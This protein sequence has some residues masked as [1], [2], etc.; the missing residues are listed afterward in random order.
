[1]AKEARNY[2]MSIG[3]KNSDAIL[4]QVEDVIQFAV[5]EECAAN[6]ECSV[7][8]DFLKRKPV[9]HIEYTKTKS[10]GTYRDSY[11]TPNKGSSGG[12]F[13]SSGNKGS[14]WGSSSS[15][16]S[17]KPSSSNS[18]GLLGGL[19]GGLGSFFGRKPNTRNNAIEVAEVAEVAEADYAG[20]AAV[21]KYCTPRSAPDLGPKFSTVIK[22]EALDGWVRFCDGRVA[23]TRILSF[24]GNGR[25]T[26]DSEG[27]DDAK[28]AAYGGGYGSQRGSQGYG[29]FKNE[30]NDDDSD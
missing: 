2:N 28:P 22:V 4:S 20:G 8:K 6:E 1:M 19:F 3:L 11:E 30:G 17:K 12:S 24:E 14:S 23:D 10:G 27:S 5:N 25:F 16:A 21:T 7:Y 26:A 9:F 15:S 13:S 18:G 29:S